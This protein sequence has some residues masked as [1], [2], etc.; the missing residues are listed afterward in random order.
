MVSPKRRREAVD[1]LQRNFAVSER[2]ACRVTHQ[3][4][5][6]QRYLGT[7]P[8]SDGPL[9]E[10]I[11]EVVMREPRAGYRTVTK[12]LRR[13]GWQVKRKRV[14]RLW[15]QEGL[16][17]PA[18][19][20]RK[21]ARGS[22][23]GSSQLREADSGDH[24]WSDDFIFDQTGDEGRLKWWAI[25]DEYRRDLMSLGGARSMTAHDVIDQL[26]VLVEQRGIPQLIRSHN[27]P[28]FLAKAVRKWIEDRGFETIF[29]ASGSPWQ[30]ACS[31]SF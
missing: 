21:R 26:E 17:V 8:S 24:V 13:D 16:K 27:D 18:K 9:V 14:H 3:P 6:T 20:A 22:S 2:R 25:L 30:N 23:D 12:L 10:A 5:A 11:R 19:P 29:I 15:K 4:R 28:E 31:E 1:A 7:K